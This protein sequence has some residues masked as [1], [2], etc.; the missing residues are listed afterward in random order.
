MDVRGSAC[1]ESHLRFPHCPDNARPAVPSIRVWRAG[2]PAGKMHE[3]VV[4][5]AEKQKLL[6]APLPG[7]GMPSLAAV[8]F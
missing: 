2:A 1:E 6:Q 3:A 7:R 8:V 4:S 5:A